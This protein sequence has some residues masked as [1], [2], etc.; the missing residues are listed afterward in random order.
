MVVVVTMVVMGI[1]TEVVVVVVVKYWHWRC[2]NS[3]VGF[4]SML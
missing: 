2:C 3:D 4:S 1:M